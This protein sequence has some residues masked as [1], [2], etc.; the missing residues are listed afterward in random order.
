LTLGVVDA[1]SDD[2]A[3]AALPRIIQFV[4]KDQSV[5]HVGDN[6][7]YIGGNVTGSAIGAGA[8]VQANDIT[9]GLGI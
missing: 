9:G 1:S 6:S 4:A 8:N 3:G 5:I 2:I 7:V